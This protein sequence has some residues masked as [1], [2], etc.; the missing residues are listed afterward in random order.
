MDGGD[1]HVSNSLKPKQYVRKPFACRDIPPSSTQA[2]TPSG[3]WSTTD[4]WVRRE[5]RGGAMEEDG[6]NSAGD[7]RQNAA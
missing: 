1:Y 6:E 7:S 4:A 2:P 5:E 3:R